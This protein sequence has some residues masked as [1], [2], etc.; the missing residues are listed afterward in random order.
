MLVHPVVLTAK[1]DAIMMND[2][3][4]DT[5]DHFGLRIRNIAGVCTILFGRL[6]PDFKSIVL[7]REFTINVHL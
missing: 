1:E 2:I 6:I 5:S 3:Q 4:N 7:D